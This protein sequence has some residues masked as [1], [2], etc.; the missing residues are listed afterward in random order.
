MFCWRP[1]L[2]FD[3]LWKSRNLLHLLI[4][5]GAKSPSFLCSLV[6]GPTTWRQKGEFWSF[7]K[8]LD[9]QSEVSWVC[10]SDFN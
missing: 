6:Y 4:N 10:I 9:K 5:P 7:M 2:K 1:E 3:I 8:E